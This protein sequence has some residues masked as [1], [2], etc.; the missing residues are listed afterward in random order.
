MFLFVCSFICVSLYAEIHFIFFTYTHW[1]IKSPHSS[2]NDVDRLGPVSYHPID[3]FFGI[4]S[5]NSRPTCIVTLL[6]FY[7]YE[8]YFSI[9]QSSSSTESDSM[10]FAN[11]NAGTIRT[12]ASGRPSDYSPVTTRTGLPPHPPSSGSNRQQPGA[13]QSQQQPQQQQQQRSEPADVLNDIGNM[14]ANLTDELDAMLEEE[15]R[16][17]QQ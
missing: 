13:R 1:Q 8:M 12:R 2:S 14:L 16:L 17:E 9:F 15:K 10:P 6:V 4:I 5:V 7:A 3:V 11:E